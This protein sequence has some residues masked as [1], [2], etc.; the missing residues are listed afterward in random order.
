MS[1]SDLGIKDPFVDDAIARLVEYSKVFQDPSA[2]EMKVEYD[3]GSVVY[4]ETESVETYMQGD[5]LK[6]TF[7]SKPY[8]FSGMTF[9]SV[10]TRDGV[11]VFRHD[12]PFF[13]EGKIGISHTITARVK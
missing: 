3:D 2:Y 1:W 10:I 11:D 12:S 8:Y 6:L 5:Y 9:A 13:L 4:L 7:I